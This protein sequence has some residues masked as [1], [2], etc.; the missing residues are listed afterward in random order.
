MHVWQ[1]PPTTKLQTFFKNK[2][3]G[4]KHTVCLRYTGFVVAL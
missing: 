4:G 2:I 3:L 1:K